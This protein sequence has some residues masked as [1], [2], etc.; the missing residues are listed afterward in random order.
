MR[1]VG[2]PVVFTKRTTKEREL[3]LTC[4]ATLNLLDISAYVYD[5]RSFIDVHTLDVN[6]RIRARNHA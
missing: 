1:T 4:D 6:T 2:L 3:L 5:N